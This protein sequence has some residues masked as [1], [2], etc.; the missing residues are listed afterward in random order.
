MATA[1]EMLL[2]TVI[3]GWTV[4]KEIGTFQGMTG[5]NFSTGYVVEKDGKKAFLKAMDLHRA[6]NKGLD[7]IKETV[8]QHLFETNILSYCKDHRLTGVVRLYEHGEYNPTSSSNPLDKIY[9]LIFEL[10]DGDIRKEITV[11]GEKDHTWKMR[12]LHQSAVA[13]VQL[14]GIQIAHQD[15]K[16]SNV[17]S[18]NQDN[19]FKIGDLGRSNCTKFVAPTDKYNYPGDLSYAPPEYQFKDVP[20]SY[21]DKRLGSDAYLLGSLISFLFAGGTGALLATFHH[22]PET[23]WPGNWTGTYQDAL[24]Y[25]EKAHTEATLE[26]KKYLPTAIA[27]ELA[28]AYFHL[29]H[30]DPTLR[31]H[32][33]ARRQSGKQIGIDRYSSIFDRLMHKV[34]LSEK[35]SRN[36]NA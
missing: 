7:A 30:P 27:E 3:D 33:D 20:T 16:P 36:Q 31:G 4:S 11:G 28:T 9:Y 6:F 25:L 10:A 23:Y 21:V 2:N 35:I 8:D 12:V 29:C 18:F 13:I 24:P 14:H 17:L 34:Q 5:G 32:P 1:A 22:L 19:R 15:L 26:L